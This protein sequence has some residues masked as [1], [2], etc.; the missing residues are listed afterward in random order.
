MCIEDCTILFHYMQVILRGHVAAVTLH[1]FSMQS[2]DDNLPAQVIGDLVQ[3]PVC[4][5]KYFFNR[6]V[7]KIIESVIRLPDHP[8][9]QTAPDSESDGIF[10]YA[11]EVLTLSLLHAEF[12]DAIKEGD[13]PRVITCWKF[14]LLIFKAANRSKYAL[15]AATLLI[16]LKVLPERIQHQF[17]W[18]RFINSSGHLARNIPCDLHM[19]HLNRIAKDALGQHS[20]FN[21][22]SVGRVGR[23][24]GLFQNVKRQF[25]CITSVHN[26]SGGHAHVVA[27]TDTT[28]IM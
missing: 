13:G 11:Q 1:Y 20:A 24:V 6:I 17:L 9:M 10:Q 15:E 27:A 16:S 23:C 12:V 18:C 28:K 3:A 19:E 2:V 14:F 22:K 7:H 26:T 5:R 25:D 21:P 8:G 4:Q